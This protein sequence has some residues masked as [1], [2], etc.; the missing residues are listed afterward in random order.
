MVDVLKIAIAATIAAVAVQANATSVALGAGSQSLTLYGQGPVAP[1][2]GSFKVGQGSSSYDGTTSTFTFS[3]AIS[4]GDPGFNSG[5]YSFVTS[6]AGPDTTEGGPAAPRAQSNPANV[7]QFFY[8]FLDPTTTV[9][10]F[11]DT[12]G[13]IYAI[14]LVAGGNFVAG[15]GFDF[16]FTTTSCTGVAVCGQNNVGLTPRATIAGPVTIGASFTIATVAPGVPEPA[17]W[18]L[19]VLGFG[20]VGVSARYRNKVVVT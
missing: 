7:N 8:T 17:S 11:L 13:Q 4:G 20:L 16:Q 12:P 5:T 1:G 9:T 10:L 19:M 3:G 6:Y 14:P 15:G 2:I 18:A